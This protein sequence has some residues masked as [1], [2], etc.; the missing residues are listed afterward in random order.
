MSRGQTAFEY[1]LILGGSVL[2]SAV[3]LV[4]V[5]GNLGQVAPGTN[6]SINRLSSGIGGSCTDCDAVFVNEGQ[7]KSITQTMLADDVVI[8]GS[9]TWTQNG[10]NQH[11]A[12]SGNVGIGTDNPSSKLTVNGTVDVSNNTITGLA[13]PINGADAVNKEYVDA[14][15]SSGNSTVTIN[16]TLY[17]GM[18]LQGV[19][20]YGTL[21]TGFV[22]TIPLSL[23]KANCGVKITACAT[24]SG[25]APGSLIIGADPVARIDVPNNRHS[26]INQANAL[27]S[28]A[29]AAT[30][31]SASSS[32]V[33]CGTFTWPTG[34]TSDSPCGTFYYVCNAGTYCVAQGFAGTNC[35]AGVYQQGTCC[36]TGT[37]LTSSWCYKCPTT[38][39][40]PDATGWVCYNSTNTNAAT[41]CP[42]AQSGETFLRWINTP[43]SHSCV[44]YNSTAYADATKKFIFEDVAKDTYVYCP[45]DH[46]VYDTTTK[47]CIKANTVQTAPIGTY[48]STLNTYLPTSFTDVTFRNSADSAY[49]YPNYIRV[50]YN[51]PTD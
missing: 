4:F 35:G 31:T 16:S 32:P 1:L 41:R 47:Y 9:S 37:T 51:C 10:T 36:P 19:I 23:P 22:N 46:P 34:A 14:A 5:H 7:P 21:S 27:M 28:A 39:P 2:L 33:S 24:T 12:L 15:G 45:A 43:T 3:V 44:Y 26:P 30:T 40:N 11:S 17:V 29:V 18:P 13:A 25:N 8:G 42:A 6:L 48:C 49:V 50:A 20:D 38:H